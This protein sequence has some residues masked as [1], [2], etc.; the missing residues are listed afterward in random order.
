MIFRILIGFNQ[1]QPGGIDSIH[2]HM[3]HTCNGISK[4]G[5][6]IVQV[7]QYLTKFQISNDA[8][9]KFC[10]MSHNLYDQSKVLT[11]IV[12]VGILNKSLCYCTSCF[13]FKLE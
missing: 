12:Q 13:N 7:L 11:Y 1:I 3:I 8:N 6:T 5:K 10:Q 9:L 4:M 2:E